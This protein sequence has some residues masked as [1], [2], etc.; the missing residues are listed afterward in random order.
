MQ[1]AVK[2]IPY[3]K[4][5]QIDFVTAEKKMNLCENATAPKTSS[6][7]FEPP[8]SSEFSLFFREIAKETKNRP[9]IL[10]IISPYTHLIN[11]QY[12]FRQFLTP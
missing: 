2:D 10:S 7:Q 8:T 6:F 4:L 3:L 5:E 12:L 1:R 11:Y 9:A